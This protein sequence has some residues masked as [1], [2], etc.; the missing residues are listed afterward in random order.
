MIFIVSVRHRHQQ[1]L[2]HLSHSFSNVIG[3]IQNVTSG[4][5]PEL[6]LALNR[7]GHHIRETIV[8]EARASLGRSDSNHSEQ[9][10]T[11]RQ[12]GGTEPIPKSQDE[13]NKQADAAI[14]DLFPRIPNTDRQRLIDRSFKKVCTLTPSQRDKNSSK[15]ISTVFFRAQ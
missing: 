1:T 13:I 5:A 10:R 7:E 15:Q 9:D 2:G 12:N 14:R 6:S 11:G 8:E 3:H 4:I